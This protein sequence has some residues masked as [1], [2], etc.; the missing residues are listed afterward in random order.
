MNHLDVALMARSFTSGRG[1]RSSLVRH[2]RL[3]PKPIAIVL[4]QLGGEPFSAA[5]IGWGN[6]HASLQTAVAGEP[7]N[8]GL[9]FGALLEF[10][11]WFNPRFE[12]CAADRETLT[13]GDYSFTVSRTAPQILVANSATVELLGKLGRRLAYLPTDGPNAVD[14]IIVRLGRHLRFLWDHHASPGQQMIVAMTDLMNAHWVTAQSGPERQSLP[15]LEAF[16]APPA[17]VSGFDAA[18]GAETLPAGPA[19]D[20]D[21]EQRL[22]P[23][24][25]EFNAK[26]K[27]SSD[28]ATVGPFLDPIRRHYQPL[29]RRTWDLLWRCRER[30]LMLPEA[31]SVGRRWDSDRQSYTWH[32]D[33]LARNGL[34]KT[35]QSPRQAATS[36]R[37]TE[38]AGRLLEAEEA[39]DDP[40]R[41]AGYVLANKAVRGTVSHVDPDHKEPGPKRMVLRPLV[42]LRSPDPCLIPVGRELWWT[43]QPTGREFVVEEIGDAPNGGSDIVLKL[44]TSTAAA[45]LP[46]VGRNVCFSVH[47][48]KPEWLGKLPSEDP[49]TH[50]ASSLPPLPQPIEESATEDPANG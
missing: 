8:R 16:I 27:G 12:E 48:T 41:M 44:M 40:L 24:V 4:W 14:P 31:D 18:A 28:P 49:W 47:S 3:V 13:R 6:E 46:T 26:R 38:E 30:E 29:L 9:A 35:R 21:D 20:G 19:P 10:A 15:A 45:S 34:R 11:K 5:A 39:C 32:M 50:K 23:L 43:E 42:T 25:E 17:G 22:I 7:R 2:R 36:L 37:N 33:W 1:V